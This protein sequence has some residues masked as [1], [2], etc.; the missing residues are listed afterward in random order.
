MTS[1]SKKFSVRGPLSYS[2]FRSW[3]PRENISKLSPGYFALVMAT[4][5]VSIAAHIFDYGMIAEGLLYFNIFAYLWLLVFSVLRFIFYRQHGIADFYNLNKSP[6]FLSFVAG[7]AVL[8]S[9]FVLIWSSYTLGVFMY[10]LSVITRLFLIYTFFT[11]ITIAA[12]K[13]NFTKSING[14]GC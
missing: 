3:N 12:N 7:S 13:P 5:I 8:S 11:V 9:Q 1:D 10:F 14:S 2:G 6:G 4:G